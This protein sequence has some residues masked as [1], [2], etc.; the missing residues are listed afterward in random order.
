MQQQQAAMATR[1]IKLGNM[2]TEADLAN[3]EEYADIVEDT[4]EECGQYG[5]VLNV[6][7]RV[8]NSQAQASFS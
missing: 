5:A 3:D 2:V 1:V 6:V 7:I 8:S 4:R